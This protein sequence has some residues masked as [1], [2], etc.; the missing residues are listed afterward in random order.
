MF[1]M[2]LVKK[3]GQLY[4][5]RVFTWIRVLSAA[6]PQ[7]GSS[8]LSTPTLLITWYILGLFASTVFIPNGDSDS[9]VLLKPSGIL[10]V[11]Y[12]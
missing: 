7:R 11:E 6:C 8:S 1:G 12:L 2:Y 9:F 4:V 5:Q 3:F 10:L